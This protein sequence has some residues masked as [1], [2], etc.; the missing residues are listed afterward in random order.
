MTDEQVR[1]NVRP[2]AA[3]LEDGAEPRKEE[4]EAEDLRPPPP[5]A[6]A[7]ALGLEGGLGEVAV[8]VGVEVEAGEGEDDVEQLVLHGDEDLGEGVEGHLTLVIGRPEGVEEDGG[9]GEEGEVLNVGVAV[10]R[11]ISLIMQT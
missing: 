6:A 5:A 10:V 8:A 3:A 11:D 4:T 1:E 7:E 9:D 2:G